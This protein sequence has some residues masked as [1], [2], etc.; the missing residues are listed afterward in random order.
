MRVDLNLEYVFDFDF[1]FR[2]FIFQGS[3]RKE[4]TN[5]QQEQPVSSLFCE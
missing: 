5:I 3:R 1:V 2:T 4:V